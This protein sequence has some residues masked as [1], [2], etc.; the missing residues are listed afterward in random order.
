MPLLDANGLRDGAPAEASPN[1]TPVADLLA[2]GGD[3]I[4][5]AFPAFSDGRGFSLARALREAG[6]RGRLR[7][8]GEL[9]PDQFAF[10]LDSGFD[11]IEISDERLARQ[12]LAQW[13]AAASAISVSYQPDFES[14]GRIIDIFARRKAARA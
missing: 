5:I 3:L 13:L 1:T 7:A 8:V 12:P 2:Q 10:A 9:I 6:Y 11:E 14:E 4:A